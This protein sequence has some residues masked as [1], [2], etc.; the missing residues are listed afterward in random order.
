MNLGYCDRVF[1]IW[2]KQHFKSY[3]GLS[4]EEVQARLARDL[5]DGLSGQVF[6]LPNHAWSHYGLTIGVN[7]LDVKL[8]FQTLR[9][10]QKFFFNMLI[11]ITAVD[12]MDKRSPRFEV[13]YQ[14]L[15]L[16]HMHRL[17]VK[18]SVEESKAEVDTVSDLWPAANFLEREVW[19]MFGIAFKGHPDLRRI[20]LYD[21]FVGHPLRKD[22]P[23]QK[24]QP[25]IP[26]RYPETRND[27]LDMSREPIVLLSRSNSD[28][29]AS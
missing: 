7:P 13:V 1:V 12:W 22:Y 29:K 15:S 4:R 26:L 19:D 24:K 16:T 3:M 20:L 23:I 28:C 11:D 21:E 2:L 25:R 14:L 17:C 18:V 10:N 9:D 8:V 27:S 5:E 6:S